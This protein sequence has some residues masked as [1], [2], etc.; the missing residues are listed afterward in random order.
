MDQ[1]RDMLATAKH[2][3]DFNY[4]TASE[5]PD[6]YR[7]QAG[8]LA[9]TWVKLLSETTP[10]IFHIELLVEKMSAL[11]SR[12]ASNATGLREMHKLASRWVYGL[13]RG[14]GDP[15]DEFSYLWANLEDG[16]SALH[17]VGSGYV[18]VQI[19]KEG[20]PMTLTIEDDL[21]AKAVEQKMIEKGVPILHNMEE[22]LAFVAC[23]HEIHNKS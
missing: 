1:L 13:K 12:G 7:K 21:L 11:V 4:A 5:Y 15:V 17:D 10:S 6:E 16:N 14:E 19:S 8:D 18:I 23:W 3:R 9:A 2:Y 20:T 22:Y